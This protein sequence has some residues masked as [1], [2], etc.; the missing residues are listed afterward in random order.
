MSDE[1]LLFLHQ[2]DLAYMCKRTNF[3]WP[4]DHTVLLSVDRVVV[5][6]CVRDTV[7]R[8]CAEEEEMVRNQTTMSASET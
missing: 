1:S 8:E 2:K 6:H 4:I 5:Q 3:V 7:E